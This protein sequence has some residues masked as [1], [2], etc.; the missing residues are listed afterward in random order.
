MTRLPVVTGA[1][2]I[3]VLEQIGFA[4]VRTKGSHAILRNGDTGLGVTIPLHKPLKRGTLAAVLR[5]A[6]I[7]QEDFAAR[8]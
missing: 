2:A 3:K 1:Q 4:H 7:D 6:G 8:L 5:Q